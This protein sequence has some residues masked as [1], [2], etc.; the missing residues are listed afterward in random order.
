M[1]TAASYASGRVSGLSTH[2]VS[3]LSAHG[4]S[5]ISGRIRRTASA[6][7]ASWTSGGTASA[8]RS[9]RW[10]AGR[11]ARIALEV[12]AGGMA[13]RPSR[14]PRS[15]PTRCSATTWR[16][17]WNSSRWPPSGHANGLSRISTNVRRSESVLCAATTTT[18][19]CR[20]PSWSSTLSPGNGRRRSITSID[21]LSRI[22]RLSR[23]P[24][25][26][27][28][29]RP[30]WLP[31]RRIREQTPNAPGTP[32]KRRRWSTQHSRRWHANG[33]VSIPRRT[34][35]DGRSAASSHDA[36]SSASRGDESGCGCCSC[37]DAPCCAGAASPWSR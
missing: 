22:P 29:A 15:R 19:S 23:H 16:S 14:C 20:C 11:S 36:G 25:K 21:S 30:Q 34:A 37:Y 26:L 32:R 4:T 10:P 27:R 8:S 6:A 35:H 33:M 12:R 28:Q 7:A 31:R 17:A 5:W 24:R 9:S 2:G 13:T 18:C 1:A 3:G